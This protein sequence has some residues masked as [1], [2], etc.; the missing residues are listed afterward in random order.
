MD[1]CA[2]TPAAGPRHRAA[3]VLPRVPDVPRPRAART[4]LAGASAALALSTAVAL[5]APA[6]AAPATPSQ[7]EVDRARAATDTAAGGVAAVE[8]Q[9]VAASQALEE[10]RIAA[11]RAAEA[12]NAASVELEQRTAA[13]TTASTTATGA[14]ARVEEARAGMGRLAA[15]S[16]RSVGGLGDLEALLADGGP[17]DLLERTAAVEAVAA[18]RARVHRRLGSAQA[19]AQLLDELAAVSLEQQRDA[20]AAAERAHRAAAGAAAEATAM[21]A[22]TEATREQLITQLAALRGTGVAL[23][24]RRQEGLEVERVAAEE[25]AARA[26]RARRT[27]EARDAA[28]AAVSSRAPATPPP[29]RAPAPTPAPAASPAPTP[30]PA[31]SPAPTPAPAATPTPTPTSAPAP[32]PSPVPARTSAPSRTPEPA[33]TAPVPSAPA[34]TA[35]AP[36]APAPAAGRSSSSAAAGAAAVAWAR[37][38]LGKP[39]LWGGSGPESFDCSG[40]TSQALRAAGVSVPRTSASQYAAAAKVSYDELRPGDLVFYGDPDV[41]S[42]VWHVAVYSGGGRMIEAPRAGVP[43]RET[44]LRMS[45]AMTWAGR[46]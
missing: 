17:Q 38:Q 6:G 3:P 21:V 11:A 2:Q 36:T 12:Y 28:A 32:T 15:G 10:S 31:A 25:R 30:A 27:Q 29:T 41:P 23:E 20:A 45:N 40:L 33:P 13:A 5:A 1:Q 46:P 35:P 43:V 16:Y 44:A 7:E 26:D 9:L 19:V 22:T 37:G 24:R 39:Y 18:H 4:V 42:S 8:A 14:T 34:P